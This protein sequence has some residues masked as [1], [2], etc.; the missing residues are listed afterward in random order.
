MT[1]VTVR[2]R[3]GLWLHRPTSSLPESLYRSAEEKRAVGDLEEGPKRRK[4]SRKQWMGIL[5]KRR[6]K[7]G[8]RPRD[9]VEDGEPGAIKRSRDREEPGPSTTDL[10]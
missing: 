3:A 10:P 4:E 2:V 6:A 8:G 1:R 5:E 7:P 9:E